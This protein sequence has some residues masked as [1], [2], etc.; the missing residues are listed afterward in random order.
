MVAYIKPDTLDKTRRSGSVFVAAI[1][2]GRRL[3]A[4]HIPSYPTGYPNGLAWEKGGKRLFVTTAESHGVV[5]D[6]A[7]GKLIDL[8]SLG[9]GGEMFWYEPTKIF[10]FNGGDNSSILDLETL[11]QNRLV[12]GPYN[13]DAWLDSARRFAEH[14]R[15][16]PKDHPSATVDTVAVPLTWGLTTTAIAIKS[17]DGSYEHLLRIGPNYTTFVATPDLATLFVSESK[18]VDVTELHLL[19]LGQRPSPPLD[20]VAMI[21]SLPSP[22]DANELLAMRAALRAGKEVYASYFKPRVN[23]LNQ[24]TVG[25]DGDEK[26]RVRILDIADDGTVKARITREID[27]ASTG[28]VLGLFRSEKM[29]FGS[30]KALIQRSA[31]V[32][33]NRV[34]SSSNASTA[35]PAT[36]MT[37]EDAVRN[38]RSSDTAVRSSSRRWLSDAAQQGDVRSA[39]H[40]GIALV[41]GDGGSPDYSTAVPFLQRA[42]AASRPDAAAWL[43]Y[44]YQQGYGVSRDLAEA[45]RLFKLAADSGDGHSAKNAAEMMRDGVGGAK[46]PRSADI[47]FEKAFTAMRGRAEA[48]D[49]SDQVLVAGMLAQGVGTRKDMAAAVVWWRRAVSQ[50]NSTALARLGYVIAQGDGVPKDRDSGLRMLRQAAQAGNAE[51]VQYLSRLGE[52]PQL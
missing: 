10:F 41:T 26:G 12:S 29:E 51:A 46:D 7:T 18:N 22:S 9:L 15:R 11:K 30:V 49:V 35:K 38:L 19:T 32:D 4:I 50:G 48:G 14:L 17:R 3:K 34:I 40:L 39:E 6:V 43:A 23:P 45:R 36:A 2:S 13:R 31:P 28:D 33:P 42:V 16:T 24:R 21:T 27:L 1:P 25:S 8:G 44:L 20:V 5:I 37:Y 52:K 47:Y